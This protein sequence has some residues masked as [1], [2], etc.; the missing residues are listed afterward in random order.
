MIVYLRRIYL[1]SYELHFAVDRF[2]ILTELREAG[3]CHKTADNFIV[4]NNTNVLKRN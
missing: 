1:I 2:P 3:T 4:Q